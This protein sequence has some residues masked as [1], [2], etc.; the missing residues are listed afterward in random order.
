MFLW[1]L[2]QARVVPSSVVNDFEIFS[3]FRIMFGQIPAKQIKITQ[4]KQNKKIKLVGC[5]PR[6]AHLKLLA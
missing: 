4:N 1:F 5:L 3:F 6:S 2:G